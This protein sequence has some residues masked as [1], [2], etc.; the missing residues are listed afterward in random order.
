ML[1]LFR[2]GRPRG[3]LSFFF[4]ALAAAAAPARAAGDAKARDASGGRVSFLVL[5]SELPVWTRIARDFEAAHPGVRVELVEGPNATDLRENLYT[6]ALLAGD[7][8]FDLVY[9]D[10]TWTPK[11]AAWLRP[12]EG[13]FR[14]D[15]IAKL[16]PAAV[17]AG[18][19]QGRL[20]RVPV[21]TDVGLLYY[22]RDLLERSGLSPP[23]T[24][25]ELARM[26]G[27][28][29]SPPGLWGYVWP[30]SQ[31]EG[32][33]CTYL[34]V[35]RAY[36]GF[37]VDPETLEVGLERREAVRALDFLRDS[38]GSLGISPP[39][40]TA[41]KED[42]SRRLFQD[43]RA[44]FLRNWPYVWRLAEAGDSAVAGK[45]GVLPILPAASNGRAGGTLGGWGFGIS[46]TSPNPRLAAEFIRH[47][48]SLE[49]QRA[50][51]AGTGYL[52]A[53]SEAYRDPAL[54]AANP[55]LPE[56]GRL[57][58]NAVL[59]PAIPRYA[60]VSDILQRHLSA[61]LAGAVPSGEALA[62]A[63]RETRLALRTEAAAGTGASLPSRL[64]AD[65]RLRAS[66]RNTAVFTACSVLLEMLVG[67]LLALLLDRAFRGRGAL[68]AVVLLPWALPTAVIALAWAWIF[69]DSFGV[70][71]DLLAR[72]RLVSGPV[73]WLSEG[74]SAMAALVTAD[75]WKTSPFVALVI[76]AGLQGIPPQLLEAARIDGLS[77]FQRFRRVV[78]PLLVPSLLV[79]L[80][81]RAVQ[82]F[83][84]FDLVYVMTGGGP[85][86]STET[87]SLYAF[88]ST[89]RYLDFGY[90]A[91]VALLGF[92]L[93][94]ALAGAVARLAR[95]RWR[96]S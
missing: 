92:A 38:R 64:W 96:R 47:A 46:K 74:A 95:P 37:W 60:L 70:A 52:P 1:E 42:E 69:N 19:F 56:L 62:S 90:G 15:E 57:Q 89:F 20:Y 61:A 55:L 72:A 63:A 28:L 87:I 45:V 59:R 27:R 48:I 79:A 14:A 21:R 75:V 49:G 11:F 35:L 82:A 51:C 18:R 41:Y 88:E 86:G 84:A 81:F 83:G 43:G 8:S 4:A 9:M 94:L 32:L 33:V 68:R 16:V 29:Q 26:A 54:V 7:D 30:G 73:A 50:L 6:A 2:R 13:D 67:T 3:V 23:T 76:L 34:E 17:S 53:L 85:G 22:R 71:N 80:L 40:V 25:G 39:G 10:V 36:G 78:L 58:E 93:A 91:A 44:V 24:L 77:P 65:G 66:L 5:A 31:Y 12:L